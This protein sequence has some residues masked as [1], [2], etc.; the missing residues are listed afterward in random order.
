VSVSERSS[1]LKLFEAWTYKKI[2]HIV[3]EFE[4]SK[5]LNAFVEAVKND[6]FLEAGVEWEQIK[7]RRAFFQRILKSTGVDLFNCKAVPPNFRWRQNQGRQRPPVSTQDDDY[8]SRAAG[9]SDGRRMQRGNPYIREDGGGRGFQQSSFGPVSVD[10]DLKSKP[11]GTFMP[12]Q[13]QA[14]MGYNTAMMN[15]MNGY[16]GYGMSS[17]PFFF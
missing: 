6:N 3:I 2:G 7:N 11:F 14:P 8:S 16:G 10:S 5:G 13:N 17:R 15:N 4:E 12:N 1:S 9:F